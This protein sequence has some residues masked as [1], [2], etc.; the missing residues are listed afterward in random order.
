MRARIPRSCASADVDTTPRGG[1]SFDVLNLGPADSVRGVATE[2][3]VLMPNGDPSAL[4]GA[5][6]LLVVDN[7][8]R[9]TFRCEIPIGISTALVGIPF[10]LL[11][12]R[13]AR[14]GSR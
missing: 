5:S 1:K 4:I 8:S 11:V 2:I 9:L 12:L 3:A 14:K 6:Y 7:L 10:F 13:N